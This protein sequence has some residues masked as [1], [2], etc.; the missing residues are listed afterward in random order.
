MEDGTLTH[1]DH[2]P[3]RQGFGEPFGL[4]DGSIDNH[5]HP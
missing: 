4:R 3:T 2:G 5:N 1:L